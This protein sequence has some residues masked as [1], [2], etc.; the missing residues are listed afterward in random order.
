M[1]L[2]SGKTGG[3]GRYTEP[4][5]I[6]TAVKLLFFR[7]ITVT[8]YAKYRKPIAGNEKWEYVGDEYLKVP[9]REYLEVV[10]VK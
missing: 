7:G 6:K 4:P 2:S 3:S 8:K 9:T 5:Y 1:S 10:K